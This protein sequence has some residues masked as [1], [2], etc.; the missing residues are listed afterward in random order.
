MK[1]WNRFDVILKC[2][3]LKI[4]NGG[5]DST[6]LP[7]VFFEYFYIANHKDCRKFQ[8]RFQRWINTAWRCNQYTVIGRSCGLNHNIFR[9]F[10]WFDTDSV[11]TFSQDFNFF[12]RS[13]DFSPFNRAHRVFFIF[14]RRTLRAVRFST[15]ISKR[16]F[17]FLINPRTGLTR[18]VQRVIYKPA[19]PLFFFIAFETKQIIR[20]MGLRVTCSLLSTC[21]TCE[22]VRCVFS[23]YIQTR[24][25]ARIRTH[26]YIYIACFCCARIHVCACVQVFY[27]A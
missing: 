2:I 7:V 11:T 10:R 8:R 27:C 19:R 21:T 17:F 23:I 24:F 4:R 14:Q 18:A 22:Y 1:I 15:E 20:Y 9:V 16:Y 6:R 12:H 3:H 13:S 25:I 5:V 26:V